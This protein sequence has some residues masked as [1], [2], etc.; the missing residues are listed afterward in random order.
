MVPLILRCSIWWRSGDTALQLA[1]ARGFVEVVEVLLSAG[2]NA[3]TA[4]RLGETPL[5]VAVRHGRT[6]LYAPLLAA[7]A[8]TDA[9][10]RLGRTAAQHAAAEVVRELARMVHPQRGLGSH[11]DD[12][13]DVALADWLRQHGVGDCEAERL[14]QALPPPC[15]VLRLAEPPLLRALAQLPEPLEEEDLILLAQ[16]CNTLRILCAPPAPGTVA[17]GQA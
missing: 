16:R 14:L 6:A 7:G 17:S 4:N 5:H 2:A 11:D 3:G 13:L 9:L 8:G 12:Q 15:D 1:V 10:D